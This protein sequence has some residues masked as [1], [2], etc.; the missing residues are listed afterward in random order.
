MA[1]ATTLYPVYNFR[2][3]YGVGEY[4]QITVPVVGST[5]VVLIYQALS[6]VFPNET[7]LTKTSKWNLITNS[8]T[9]TSDF[10]S[11]YSA[12]NVSPTLTPTGVVAGTYTNATVTVDSKGRI[13]AISSGGSGGVAW[14]TVNVTNALSP[15]TPN[16]NSNYFFICNTTGGVITINQSSAPQIGDL[17]NIINDTGSANI[18][19]APTGTLIGLGQNAVLQYDGSVWRLIKPPNIVLS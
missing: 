6:P 5:P 19:F 17:Y 8:V 11:N 3:N 18:T 13:T 14:T 1:A 15:F 9:S 10:D 2:N 7:P 4:V 12:G 16:P